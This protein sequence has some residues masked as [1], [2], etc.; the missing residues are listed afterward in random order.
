MGFQCVLRG[1]MALRRTSGSGRDKKLRVCIR[2]E[3]A[4]SA[5]LVGCLLAAPLKSEVDNREDP[6]LVA[7]R[8]AVA[9]ENIFQCNIY[10][11][12]TM[13]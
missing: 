9:A 2:E 11:N 5:N 6:L 4:R 1:S 13:L 12:K 8:V 7:R 10:Y 3:R